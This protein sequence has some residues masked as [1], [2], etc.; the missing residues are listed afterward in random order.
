[1]WKFL[2]CVTK[3]FKTFLPISLLSIN[4]YRS[5]VSKLLW[6]MF[7]NTSHKFCIG[8]KKFFASNWYLSIHVNVTSLFNWKL[9]FVS[10]FTRHRR[11]RLSPS[12]L[13]HNRQLNLPFDLFKFFLL[14]SFAMISLYFLFILSKNSLLCENQIWIE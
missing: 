3:N 7:W 5:S 13:T 11:C 9:S 2:T 10:T 14:S 1:M 12:S 6:I 8:D 4:I